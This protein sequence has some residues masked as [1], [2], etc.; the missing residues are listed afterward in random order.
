MDKNTLMLTAHTAGLS[1][2]LSPM[3][4]MTN[5]SGALSQPEPRIVIPETPLTTLTMEEIHLELFDRS[6]EIEES[7][8]IEQQSNPLSNSTT[9]NIECSVSVPSGN[10]KRKRKQSF[11]GTRAD[12]TE[13]ESPK[14][15][16]YELDPT[17]SMYPADMKAKIAKAIQ[18]RKFRESQNEKDTH[19]D[20]VIKQLMQENQQLR[21]VIQRL[22][23][24]ETIRK[25]KE[26]E[27]IIKHLQAQ[28]QQYGLINDTILSGTT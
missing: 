18:S 28:L 21:E 26:K 6:L 27:D 13:I 12:N 1:I 9:L 19:K 20:K 16:L 4:P 7:E 24:E 11:E 3:E 8:D 17:N 25:L 14:I 10:N 22:E 23:P 5:W 15:Y 2:T